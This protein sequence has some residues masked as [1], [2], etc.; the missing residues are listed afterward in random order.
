VG[1]SGGQAAAFTYDLARSIVLTRQGNPAWAG[2]DR[3]GVFPIRPNDLFFGGAQT[4][5]VDVGRID[6]PQAD[7]QQRLLANLVE[8]M[9]ADRKPIP[10]F[11]YLPRG[12]KAAV[13]MTGDDHANGGTAPRFDTY[14]TQSPGGC[15]VALW[16]C[17]R[18]T[19]YIYPASPLTNAQAGAY[20]ADGF[21]I[22]VHTQIDG[23]CADWTPGQLDSLFAN[24]RAAFA[25]KY[26]NVPAP[27]TERTHCVAWSD[28]TSHAKVDRDYGVRLD[29]NY[30]HYP[31]SWIGSNPG[32][33]TGSGM[34]MRFADVDGT[35]IDVFQAHTHMTDEAGQAY[36]ATAN[37]LLDEAIG[38]EG[39]YG[40]FT[41]NMHTDF[42][43]HDGSDAIVASALARSVPVVTAKQMLDWVDG[44]DTSSFK[45]FS[46]SGSQLGFT[47]TAGAGA[48]GLQ[49]MLPTQSPAGS[50]SSITRGGSPVFF[51]T[52][53]VKGVQYAFFAAT[54]GTYAA[55]YGS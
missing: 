22:A 29:T 31:G 9:N 15:S 38:P 17:V 14:K 4:D 20:H 48:N 37:A 49:A 40:I 36:P 6:I 10:R 19:S 44:R 52:Q 5:W 46:W 21:E 32:Y 45:S 8:H 34:V 13:V 1:T 33:M 54:S 50:L 27:V 2:Q 35:P 47:V 25:S 42:D 18:A 28:Y 51:T 39:Y 16:E 7:E 3:D 30:Y 41:T 12:E 43:Q 55:A 24:Q 26:T 11:W 53:A 23:G